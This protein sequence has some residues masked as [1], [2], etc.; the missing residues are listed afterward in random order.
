[1]NQAIG[2]PGTVDCNFS[3]GISTNQGLYMSGN[4]F[5]ERTN[6]CHT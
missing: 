4:Y 1:M 2:S 6:E 3:F 5:K